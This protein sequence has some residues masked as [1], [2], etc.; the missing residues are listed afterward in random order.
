MATFDM[1]N[2]SPIGGAPSTPQVADKRAR[3]AVMDAIEALD[4][5]LV[6]WDEDMSFVF[7]NQA[8]HR[9]F[10]PGRT[11][12]P[13]EIGINWLRNQIDDDVYIIPDGL[14]K[15]DYYTRLLEQLGGY[16]EGEQLKLS[17]GTILSWTVHRT[18]LDG[19]LISFSD[20]TDRVRA[21]QE[22]EQQRRKTQRANTRLRDA[23]ESIGEGFAL[24]DADDKLVLANELYRSA[25]PAAAPFMK[26][27]HPRRDLIKAMAAG[28]DILDVQDWV[29]SYN[30]EQAD[31]DTTSSRSYEVHHSDGRIFMA[32]RR[33]TVENGC[34]VT[35]LDITDSKKTEARARAIVN[36]AIEAL[37]EGFALF[38]AD[39]RFLFCNQ[40]Y[41]DLALGGPEFE[42]AL[43]TTISELAGTLFDRGQYEMSDGATRESFV[44]QIDRVVKEYL[45]NVE[46]VR[47]DGKII[48]TSA[49]QT[50]LGG[51]L[52]TVLD[53]TEKRTAEQLELAAV[54]D[55]MQALD[56]GIALYDANF[57]FVMANLPFYQLWFGDGTVKAAEPGE[58]IGLTISRLIEAG[59][60]R[61]PEQESIQSYTEIVM[62][63]ATRFDQEL[64][65]EH[66]TGT[67]A[68]TSHKTGLGGYLFEFRDITVQRR[69]E[70][71][72]ERQR[73][74]THQ[75][76]KLTAMGEL[77]A[78]VAHELNNPL[79]I[80]VG[81]AMMMQNTVTDP[82]LGRQ[83]DNVAQ[84]AERCARIVK[85]FLAM[86]RQRPAQHA[87]CSL[88]EIVMAAVDMVGHQLR[89]AEID[90]ITELDP[91]LPD[92]EA[93]EDQII[94]VFINLLVN[95][96]QILRESPKP[97]RIHLR[98]YVDQEEGKVV[99]SVS[100]NGPGIAPDVLPR[101]FEPFYTTKDVGQGTGIGL[102]FCHRILSSHDGHLDVHSTLGNGTQFFVGLRPS[103]THAPLAD[104]PSLTSD[105]HSGRILV[106]DDEPGVAD[107]ISDILGDAGYCVHTLND[108]YAALKEIEEHQFDAVI[109]D[110]KMPG[111]D[112]PA[113]FS[114]LRR[115]KPDLA[116]RT[117]FVTGDTLSE[118]V[119]AFFDGTPQPF[120]EKPVTPAD[121][122]AFVEKLIR[123]R[124]AIT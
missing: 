45:K 39:F 91:D 108:G 81:Y 76:E 43:G 87:R 95:A 28:G 36:D 33:R 98:S 29:E 106:L 34:A 118:N 90:L 114:A 4:L 3:R 73:E 103:E 84:A 9:I 2:Q 67:V 65:M 12:S 82:K 42:P 83:I 105:R 117:G 1:T 68:I 121:V 41:K 101:I 107:L 63:A 86:A 97:R 53:V 69:I 52:V 79:S 122:L 31:G 27:G 26:P 13:G 46:F 64:L 55:A 54:T 66:N 115:L 112:G 21:E 17:N 78:G 19:Y 7:A 58:H 18:A 89:A 48:Q 16:V 99:T 32:S 102:A 85:A 109:S 74:A 10:A 110:I 44:A 11:L 113:F 75:N 24:F 61:L 124:K 119:A 80:V 37:D 56:V 123:K 49:H 116:L 96:E 88:N 20:I 50:G 40:K 71:E 94:Q 120:L 60:L 59:S 111:L 30:R 14:T 104:A 5:A 100:D 35:W 72:L 93:D 77:L 38:D 22:A 8:W 70:R 92:V 51:Y 23:L 15:D 62:D 25:N 6:L 47:A 57:K